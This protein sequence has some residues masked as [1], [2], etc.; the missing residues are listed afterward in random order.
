[1]DFIFTQKNPAAFIS[2]KA[3][4]VRNNNLLAN[5]TET[6]MPERN[7]KVLKTLRFAGA[8][9]VYNSK[10]FMAILR[11]FTRQKSRLII[12][13]AKLLKKVS[14]FLILN[15]SN[16]RELMDYT[17]LSNNRYTF[18]LCNFGNWYLFGDILGEFVPAIVGIL[19]TRSRT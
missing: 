19:E 8:V 13:R 10:D 6:L 12:E 2:K 15:Y 16:L 1:M 5:S 9:D 17:I 4:L 18:E 3:L 7:F 11:I 14:F